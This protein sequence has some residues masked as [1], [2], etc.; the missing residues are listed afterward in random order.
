MLKSKFEGKTRIFR[1]DFENGNIGYST[2]ISKKNIEDKWENSFI[3]VQ[4]K[5]GVELADKTDIEV[6]NGWLTFYLN[7][8]NKPVYQI[9][10]NEFT[11]ENEERKAIQD[12]EN[13]DITSSE[14]LPF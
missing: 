6:I 8:E 5:K 9:F 4:F 7:K 13:Y 12:E 1:K 14:D 10:I 3:N 2:T 11:A